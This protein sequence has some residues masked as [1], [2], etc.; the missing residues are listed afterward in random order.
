MKRIIYPTA[1]GIAV[2]IPADA[3]LP[4]AYIAAK[5]VPAGVPFRILDTAEIPADRSDRAAWTAD[6]SSPD[7]H[8]QDFG[9]GSDNAV[10]A[11]D[12]ETLFLR[13]ETTGELS[14]INDPTA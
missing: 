9:N 7:G 6:F 12:G 1:D 11:H 2:L 10:V 8:G 5:D 3:S 14:T 4:L 13:N